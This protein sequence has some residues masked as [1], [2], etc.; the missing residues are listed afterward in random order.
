MKSYEFLNFHRL[1]S[2]DLSDPIFQAVR[3]ALQEVLY[4]QSNLGRIYVLQQRLG[5]TS[6]KTTEI[7]LSYLAPEERQTAMFG[8]SASGT[9]TGTSTAVENG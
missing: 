6:V 7:Y 8:K 1:P 2:D 3:R 5:H 4:S 9:K